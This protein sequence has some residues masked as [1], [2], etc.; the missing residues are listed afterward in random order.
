M[1]WKELTAID[2]LDQL[3]EESKNSPVLIYKHSTSCSVSRMALDRLERKWDLE[4]TKTYFLDLLSYR[5]LSNAIA[6]RFQVVHES[7]QVLVIENGKAVY[8]SSHFDINYHD[9]RSQ[10]V[11][12]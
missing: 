4:G 1:I 5:P 10:L 2:Q 6:E 9:I 3:I 12:V 8:D 11:T 7:P